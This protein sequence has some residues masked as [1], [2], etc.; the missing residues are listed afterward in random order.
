MSIILLLK[1]LWN[2]KS[3][4]R[5]FLQQHVENISI[6]NK[7]ILDIGGGDKNGSY[8]NVLKKQGN[9]FISIDITPNCDYKIDLENEKFPFEDSS[10]DIVF[11]FNVM[12]HIYNYENMLSEIIRVM[13]P[14]AKLYFLVP[15][16]A[17][18]HAHPY[19]FHRFTD[20]CLT[21]IFLSKGFSIHKK[22]LNYG[23]GKMMYQCLIWVFSS[24]KLWWFSNL[25]HLILGLFFLLFDKV[26]NLIG[27][28]SKNMSF[29]LNIYLELE[30]HGEK[31]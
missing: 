26:I 4:Y 28:K 22:E 9:T 1:Q 13:S 6:N 12:E 21:H 14:N 11:C 3:F 15:F 2:K 8:H 5:I 27:K 25:L 31:G 23:A 30:Y 10:I 17:N 18:K 19:D 20:E 16:L 24:K 7:I 29:L